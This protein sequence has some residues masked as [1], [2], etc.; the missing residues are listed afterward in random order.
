MRRNELDGFIAK[1]GSSKTTLNLSFP[2]FTH[3][4]KLVSTSVTPF[5][6]ETSQQIASTPIFSG[7]SKRHYGDELFETLEKT[8]PTVCCR[9]EKHNNF[10]HS[11]KSVNLNFSW[12]GGMVLEIE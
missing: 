5:L 11:K 2:V 9:V 10:S 12:S 4:S 6:T 3:Y 8:G 7:K 1:L